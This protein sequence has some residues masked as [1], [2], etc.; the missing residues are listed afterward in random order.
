RRPQAPRTRAWLRPRPADLQV[1]DPRERAG[2]EAG[3]S[4]RARDRSDG[5]RPPRRTPRLTRVALGRGRD[6]RKAAPG[7]EMPLLDHLTELRGRLFK[8]LAA[9]AVGVG[10]AW[11]FYPEI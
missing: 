11:Y 6:R 3:R 9:I 7:G 1:R 4:G 2:G 10:V 5:H 8:A